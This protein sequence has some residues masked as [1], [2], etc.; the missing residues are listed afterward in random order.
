MSNEI[1]IRITVPDGVVPVVD[2][3]QTPAGPSSKAPNPECPVHHKEW[4]T[5][6]R[7]F[8]CATK[9]PDGS[10]CQQKP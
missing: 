9:M 7:G 1:V 8:Y 6:S 2:Y 4:R 5:N 3:A 10:W